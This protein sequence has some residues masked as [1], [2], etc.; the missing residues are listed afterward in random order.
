M[1]KLKGQIFLCEIFCLDPI[2]EGGSYQEEM[3]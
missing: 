2:I 3:V 1:A